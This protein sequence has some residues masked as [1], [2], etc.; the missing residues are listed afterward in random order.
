MLLDAIKT[1]EFSGRELSLGLSLASHAA[2]ALENAHL[3][4]QLQDYTSE[5]EARVLRRTQALQEI[6]E[7]IEGLLTSVPDAIFV[8]DQ[9]NQLVR[10]NQA[11]EVLLDQAKTIGMDLFNPQLLRILESSSGPDLQS[12]LE[13][14]E[15]AYQAHSSQLL[16]DNGEIT[17][18]IIVFR[19]VTRFRE[20]DQ[21]KTQFVSDVSHELRTPLTNLT[22]Y[23]GLLS[24][25]KDSAKQNEYLLTLQRETE[26]LTHLI[27]NLLTIS[28]L[29][30]NRI[31]FQIRATNLN[32]L[33]EQLVCDRAMLAAQ[34][35]ID[36]E[37][38]PND[39]LSLASADYNMLTQA[40]SNLLTNATN[41]TLPG[42]SI[43]VTL[44][45]PEDDW[46]TIKIT[47]TGVGI[48]SD[49]AEHI[50]DRF[51]R[52]SSS[53]QTGAEGTGLG[54]SISQEIIQRLDG[55]ITLET[56]PGKGS[57]FIIWLKPAPD[58]ISLTNR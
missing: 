27:E 5:L 32:L 17:G 21:M 31:Q 24:S 25:V 45:Q 44:A 16:S 11:G 33:I 42:G 26:R 49:E 4:R 14:Q 58:E 6:T 37:F 47:D 3:Y 18:Q 35:E 52:G 1:R 34:K 38:L 28:R 46:L 9:N 30:A 53:Q 36:L 43:R 50:F 2:T 8:L 57:T 56:A 19:D 12:I 10:A 13:V 51:Y 7:Y 48:P 39:H 54:L 15:R 55:K 41:Y 20:L 23:L 40:V 29:E 22:L